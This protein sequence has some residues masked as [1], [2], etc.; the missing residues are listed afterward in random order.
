MAFFYVKTGT[1]GTADQGRYASQQTGAFPTGTGAYPTITAAFGAST[2]PAAGDTI[3]VSSSHTHDYGAANVDWSCPITTGAYLSIVLVDDANCDESAIATSWVEDT[4]WS[5]R[6]LGRA[7][8]YGIWFKADT[9]FVTNGSQSQ[10]VFDQCTLEVTATNDTPLSII[11]RDSA[12]LLINTDIIGVSGGDKTVRI[13][14]GCK[15][16]M[17]G[18]SVTGITDTFINAPSNYGGITVKLIG[19]DLSSI[20]G[21]IVENI[22]NAVSDSACEFTMSGCRV[23]SSLTGFWEES[24]VNG[25]H[26]LVASNCGG[27]T[28]AGEYQQ[29]VTRRGGSVDEET[30]I[31]RDGSTAFPSTQKISLKCISTADASISTP[32]WFDAPTRYAELSSISTDLLRIFILSSAALTDSEVWAEAVYP[33]GTTKQLYNFLS[34]RNPDIFDTSGTLTTNTEAWTGRTAENRYQIDLDTSGDAGA[35]SVP[36]IRLYVAKA[37]AT[38]YFCPTIGL[39]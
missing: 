37:S 12:A 23:N 16:E 2:V 18:G 33:D 38:I 17:Y 21:H 31:Y 19:V 34:N 30:S 36:I 8:F 28:A 22:G 26:S 39:S 10:F 14:D 25:G 29:H 27:T 32:F 3:S 20:T 24:I 11:S 13:G 9:S 4:T 6:I 35:D 7:A 5:Y 1:T 15:F